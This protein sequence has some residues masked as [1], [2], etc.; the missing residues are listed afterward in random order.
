MGKASECAV[1]KEKNV[2]EFISDQTRF[3]FPY[4]FSSISIRCKVKQKFAPLTPFNS[5]QQ[6]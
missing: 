5:Q 3:L 2:L 1:K 4:L 6:A